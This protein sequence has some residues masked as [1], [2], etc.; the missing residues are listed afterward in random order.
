[1]DKT[2]HKNRDIASKQEVGKHPAL[3]V[4]K[5]MPSQTRCLTL[6]PLEELQK[7]SSITTPW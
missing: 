4:I 5:E 6:I 2:I 3:L 7:L 1:M